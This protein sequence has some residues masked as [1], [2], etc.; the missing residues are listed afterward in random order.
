MKERCFIPGAAK[1]QL[2]TFGKES[3]ST[4]RSNGK[5]MVPTVKHGRGSVLM[6]GCISDGGVVELHFIDGIIN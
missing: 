4:V 2:F 1:Q 6:W 5:C 3:N